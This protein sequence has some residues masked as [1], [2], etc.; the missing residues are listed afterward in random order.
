MKLEVT[1]GDDGYI[2]KC[3]SLVKHC[4]EGTTDLWS[5][6]GGNLYTT[7]DHTRTW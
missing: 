6:G 7:A 2:N 3:S 1:C 5:G 4:E